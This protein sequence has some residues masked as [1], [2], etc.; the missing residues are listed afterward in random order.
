[1]VTLI[2][3]VSEC[4]DPISMGKE[5][6]MNLRNA[7]GIDP[8]SQGCV[9]VFVELCQE[10]TTAKSFS[11][12]STGTGNLLRWIK[13]K[14]D[15]IVAIEG[16]NGQSKAIE[17]ALRENNIIFY[18]F[19][20]GD[21]EKFRMAVLGENKNNNRDAEA[22]A[23]LAMSLEGQGK[24]DKFKRVYFPEEGLQGLTRLHKRKTES[25]TSEINNFWKLLSSI[26]TNLYLAL[27]GN[28]SEVEINT[29]IVKTQ[30]ILNLFIEKPDIYKWKNFNESDFIDAM[31]G[32]NYIGR[33]KI[34]EE[35]CKVAQTFNPLS[36]AV[37]LMIKVTVDQIQML[38]NQLHEIEKMLKQSTKGD[39]GIEVLEKHC[40]ISTITSSTIIAEIID[41]R[42][43][44][45][46]DNLASYA[47]LTR[48]E[49][50]TGKNENTRY[51]YKFNHRLK[52][53]LMIA[54]RNFVIFNPD[55]HLTGYYKNLIKKG[56][57]LTE[58]RK[59]VARALVRIIFKDLYSV[60]NE[61]ESSFEEEKKEKRNDMARDQ[62]LMATSNQ[63]NIS[64]LINNYNEKHEKV[65]ENKNL[66]MAYP[67]I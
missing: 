59:R 10:R 11:A 39:R 17:K 45:S 2:T 62:S 46:D 36:N 25:L 58:A 30:G 21:V 54:A 49:Y 63:S 12:T 23:R 55:S 40:G 14:G 34:A 32:E 3:R 56:M 15:V 18:S 61:N 53:I 41:I 8:D 38:K 47:G 13:M 52:N 60:I 4:N 7:I 31:G 67:G 19:K 9:S 16:S 48:K 51:N 29:N 24:L 1:M 5:E 65:N 66:T 26:S 43:F 57:S 27:G 28:N 33:K 35:L 42:R 64:F 6:K 37:I 20:P 50:S 22:T 44:Q